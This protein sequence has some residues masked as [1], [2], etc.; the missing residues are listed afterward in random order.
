MNDLPAISL[1][2]FP[3]V[4]DYNPA[5][6]LNQGLPAGGVYS[7]TNVVSGVFDPTI[8]AGTY[9][10][11]YTV[12]EDGC[13]NA[14][15]K[16]ITVSACVGIHEEEEDLLSV[17]PNPSSHSVTIE[18]DN[19]TNYETIQL[20]DITGKLIEEWKVTGTKMIINI[21]RFAAGSYTINFKNS[22]GHS[23][24]KIQIL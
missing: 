2:D 7:G 19:L 23:V 12:T 9:P 15:T 8:G 11:T 6:T 24:K 1:E 3:E 14:V 16:T 22:T 17:Y 4:C 13:S 18:G 10:I 5:V 21:S 20:N